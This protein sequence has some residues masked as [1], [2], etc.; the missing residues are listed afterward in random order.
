MSEIDTGDFKTPKYKSIE[1]LN[2]Y[3]DSK[4]YEYN[5]N[6]KLATID[7]IKMYWCGMRDA[8]RYLKEYM[9]KGGE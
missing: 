3:L 1:V 4:I 9:I 5:K 8:L 7:I 6:S 2:E